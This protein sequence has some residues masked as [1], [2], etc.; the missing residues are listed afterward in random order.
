MIT[1][2]KYKGV[3]DFYP[4]DMAIQQYIFSTMKKVCQQYGYEEY[5]ASIL[6]NT[7]IY[8]AKTGSEIV[9]E[10]TYTFF[11]RGNRE[12][13]IRPEMTPTVARMVA[14]QSKS[15]LFPLRWFS[16]PNLLR[17]ENPQR[18]RLREHW[19]LNVDIFGSNNIYSDIEIISVSS[20]IMIAFGAQ[21]E[22]FEIRIGS[23]K[24]L[25]FFLKDSLQLTD[26]QG[27][28]INKLLDK[29]NKL[30]D[31]AFQTILN[32]ILQDAQKEAQVIQFAQTTDLKELANIIPSE[33]L[34]D[35]KILFTTLQKNNINNIIFDAS[36]IRGFDYY[37]DMIFE[38]F[39]TGPENNRSLFG[40][41]RYDN[42][43][44]IFG[45]SD[46]AAC[47]FGMGDVTIRDYL[48]TYNLLPKIEKTENDIYICVMSEQERNYAS[49]IADQLRKSGK[50]ITI[51]LSNKKIGKQIQDASK[52]GFLFIVIIG[53]NEQE[54]NTYVLKNLE[55]G[56]EVI[57]NVIE[58]T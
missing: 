1:P 7:E 37:T 22:N 46:I 58:V 6:E 52:K 27:Y 53:Q 42:L 48:E 31:E 5:G 40:G 51:D 23:R 57:E 10:Q 55:T 41:G 30:S 39:D 15:L 19:Q 12:V 44:N 4:A 24:I 38:V 47:G 16:I 8:R 29:K 33:I 14:A 20:N 3:R 17:Y 34:T 21:K 49:K 25:N 43:T 28:K 18:G 54:N 13:T 32:D 36:I 2:K 26:D 35:I 45:V 11:D 9:N 56:E 50:N